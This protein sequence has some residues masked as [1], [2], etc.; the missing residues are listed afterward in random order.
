M[1]DV[2]ARAHA[3]TAIATAL[4][5]I[6]PVSA[7]HAAV[8]P[9]SSA[10]PSASASATPSPEPSSSDEP[11]PS[12]EPAPTEPPAPSEEPAPSEPPAPSTAPAPSPSQEPE[13]TDADAPFAVAAVDRLAGTDQIGTAVAA[14]QATYPVGVGTVFVGNI[15]MFADALSAGAA[16]HHV[17]GALL[18]TTAS[19]LDPRVASEITRLEPDQVVLLGGATGVSASVE[20]SISALGFPV[21]RVAGADRYATSRAIVAE[22]YASA[23]SAVLVSGRVQS[24][25]LAASAAAAELGAPVIAIDSALAAVDPATIALLR[26]LGVTSVHMVGTATALPSRLD[27]SLSGAGFTVVRSSGADHAA[28][29]V[30]IAKRAFPSPAAV[31]LSSKNGFAGALAS[32]SYVA[33]LGAPLYFAEPTCVAPSVAQDA[34]GRL[35]GATVTLVGERAVVGDPVAALTVCFDIAADK[36]ILS[37]KL[38][39]AITRLPGVHSVTVQV[40]EGHERSVAIG[41]TTLREPA[42]VIKL[43]AAYVALM[44]VDQGSLSLSTKTRS[45]V[46]VGECIRV[47]IQASD[48]LCHGDL[49]ALLGQN[50]INRQL[51][52]SGFRG[53][54]YVGYDG[55][56]IY[57]SAKRTTTNDVNRLLV[58]LYKRQLL[59]PASTDLLLKHLDDQLWRSR[60][61]SGV[62][63]GVKVSNKVGELWVSTGMVQADAGIVFAE[64][65]PF[66]ITIIGERNSTREAIRSLAQVAFEHLEHP[67]D[68]RGNFSDYNLVT[69]APTAMYSGL[70]TGYLGT[71]PAR[72][73][74]RMEV[75]NRVWY[76]VWYNGRYFFV[77]HSSTVPV[78]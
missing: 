58:L 63:H 15:G 66:A 46:S 29:S 67:I 69:A 48:N 6:V 26:A 59:Q 9:S 22:S 77:R 33:A 78:Y 55:Q 14:S 4:M 23:T 20:S 68:V 64:G 57:R 60:I 19:A 25:T 39:T 1:G 10:E 2:R 50:S 16:A 76:R 54:W 47:M 13:Q 37:Q 70:G 65:E 24:D 40:L 18:W 51:Y 11:V 61:P 3:I 74:L 38:T 72:I 71:L 43:F 73:A 42:S 53:T 21:R 27:S 75:S 45:G 56:G 62:E 5:M 28:V 31:A 7:A 30:A 52:L 34:G 36:R 44:R 12:E 35:S 49:L 8:A 41:G 17:G 32:I